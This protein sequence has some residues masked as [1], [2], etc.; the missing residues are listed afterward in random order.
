[1]SVIDSTPVLILATTLHSVGVLGLMAALAGHLVWTQRFRRDIPRSDVHRWTGILL[2]TSLVANLLGGTLRTIQPD[3][4]GITEFVHSSWV[5]VMVYKHFFIAVCLGALLYLHY[6]VVPWMEKRRVA[7]RPPATMPL[8]QSV[9]VVLVVLGIVA[10]SVLGAFAQ[11]APVDLDDGSGSTD[12]GTDELPEGPMIQTVYHN[13]SG[14]L[15]S[16]APLAPDTAR[17]NFPVA[18]GT[19]AVRAALAW[20]TEDAVLSLRLIA[21]DGTSYDGVEEGAAS[22]VIQVDGPGAGDW[23]YEISSESA[24]NVAWSLTIQASENPRNERVLQGSQ[25]IPGGA[26]FEINTEMPLNGTFCWE[27]TSDADLEFDVHS[28][29][30]GEVQYHLERTSS[31]EEDCFTNDREGGYSLLW[32]PTGNTPVSLTY[33]VWGE[34]TLHSYSP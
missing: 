1:M 11:A 17:G 6:R 30:D 7:G 20:D 21:P 31:G 27:W 19:E 32:A 9:S 18:E 29:F 5:Q 34:F 8:V 25:V 10:G 28:H 23:S 4:P 22:R 13:A 15:T 3:H 26:F 14:R 12:G 24:T 16:I 33:R 2:W